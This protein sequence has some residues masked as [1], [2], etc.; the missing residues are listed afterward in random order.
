MVHVSKLKAFY[1]D[2]PVMSTIPRWL[3]QSTN[4]KSLQPEAIIDHIMVYYNNDAQV[5][6]LVKWKNAHAVD[7]SRGDCCKLC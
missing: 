5:Q 6:Y 7:N 4:T 2:P 3:N 1:D